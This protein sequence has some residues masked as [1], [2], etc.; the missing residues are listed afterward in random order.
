MIPSR[1]LK[2]RLL[3]ALLAYRLFMVMTGDKERVADASAADAGGLAVTA[4]SN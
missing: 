3:V 1:H 2:S 4:G